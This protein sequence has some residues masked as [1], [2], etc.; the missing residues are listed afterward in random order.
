MI[1]QNLFLGRLWWCRSER[2][3]AVSYQKTW[4][5]TPSRSSLKNQACC[6]IRPSWSTA[7]V[8]WSS[9]ERK[10]Y[11]SWSHTD[12]N[13][14]SDSQGFGVSMSSDIFLSE[15]RQAGWKMVRLVAIEHES[16]IK[17]CITIDFVG[18]TVLT[19]W[20]KWR[21]KLKDN[22]IWG[23]YWLCLS[24]V[25]C[26]AADYCQKHYQYFLACC[27]K[28]FKGMNNWILI[29]KKYLILHW[30]APIV[31]CTKCLISL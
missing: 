16:I 26:P 14:A 21:S 5:S 29:L 30:K 7:E 13:A 2:N 12:A 9:I 22:Y 17:W 3:H 11:L 23:F 20:G 31:P 8:N 24:D 4:S 15:H 6:Q 25:S 1:A 27:I 18:Q 19:A 10:S 28:F